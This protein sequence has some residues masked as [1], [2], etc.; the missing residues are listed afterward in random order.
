MVPYN[1]SFYLLAPHSALVAKVSGDDGSEVNYAIT[2]SSSSIRLTYLPRTSGSVVTSVAVNNL[3]LDHTYW[4]HI[5]VTVYE[6]EA[7]IYV[8]GSV[9]GALA[10]LGPIRDDAS[11]DIKLGQIASSK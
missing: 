9:V 8:N 1:V 4:H 2:V 6:N 7:A 10:L 11:R 5:A 3:D